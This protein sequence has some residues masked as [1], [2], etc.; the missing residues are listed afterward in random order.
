MVKR[1][2]RLYGCS[3]GGLG[4]DVGDTVEGLGRSERSSLSSTHIRKYLP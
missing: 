1:A 2:L 4:V 3:M